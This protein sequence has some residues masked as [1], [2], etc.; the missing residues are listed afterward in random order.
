[1]LSRALEFHSA[2]AFPIYLDC[3]CGYCFAISTAAVLFAS[4]NALSLILSAAPRFGTNEQQLVACPVPWTYE[5]FFVRTL[6]LPCPRVP[7]PRRVGQE[8][9]R[10]TNR[11]TLIVPLFLLGEDL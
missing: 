4:R 3:F 7:L 5:K 8:Q 9:A 11:Q 10:E 1:M 6:F 2:L